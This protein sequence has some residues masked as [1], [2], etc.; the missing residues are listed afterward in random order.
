MRG[1]GRG[2]GESGV[3]V[4]KIAS[5]LRCT[6][7][8]EIGARVGVGPRGVSL[9]ATPAPVPIGFGAMLV[10]FSG[11]NGSYVGY[12]PDELE[13][14]QEESRKT[15]IAKSDK[16]R[17]VLRSMQAIL[18]NLTLNKKRTMSLSLSVAE[19]LDLSLCINGETLTI[20]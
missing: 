6:N 3:G 12:A 2:C 1:E 7:T 5:E 9:S 15:R 16:Y 13:R 8:T 10:P 20:E 4:T 14:V 11:E 19:V 17:D 18:P